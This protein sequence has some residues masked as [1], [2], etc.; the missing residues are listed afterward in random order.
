MDAVIAVLLV[1][2]VLLASV[3]TWD[4][5]DS[6]GRLQEAVIRLVVGLTLPLVG[7]LVL[8]LVDFF[9]EQ[10]A[11]AQM[12][13]IWLGRG[14]VAD[15]LNLLRDVDASAADRAAPAVDVLALNDYGDRRRMIMDTLRHA[16]TADYIDVLREALANEDRETSHYASVVIMDL[17][18]RVQTR[19]A[20]LGSRLAEDPGD[21]E[22][23]EVM[24]R[25]L[26]G[27]I[28]DGVIDENSLPRYY[29]A[30]LSVSDHLLARA[31]SGA[32]KDA[33]PARPDP[34][35]ADRDV[36]GP[37]PG[38]FH[39]R[40][41]VD[42][43]RGETEHARETA[44]AYLRAHPDSE[45]AVLDVIRVCVRQSDREGLDRL[46]DRLDDLPVMLTS[47]SLRYIRFLREQC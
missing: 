15:D 1:L 42:L 22:T 9:S 13:E 11:S 2:H 33:T 24:E 7:V 27:V 37:D 43:R 6:F 40:V 31:L 38:C 39:R 35:G 20:D 34:V 16:D 36:A 28:R 19:L 46:L 17:Q 12:D 14:E 18:S 10:D 29:D 4:W 8:K 45:D 30:Y 32:E 26:Y 21:P 41:L 47:R 5:F 25:E 23:L 44:N 3:Y